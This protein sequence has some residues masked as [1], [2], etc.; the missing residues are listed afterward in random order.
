MSIGCV[1]VSTNFFN[2]K[3]MI[4]KIKIETLTTEINTLSYNDNVLDDEWLKLNE[5]IKIQ[6]FSFSKYS[7]VENYTI[8]KYDGSKVILSSDKEVEEFFNNCKFTNKELE[9]F[10][11]KKF[12]AIKYKFNIDNNKA[13]ETFQKFIDNKLKTS[14]YQINDIVS[15]KEDILY[16]MDN[17]IIPFKNDETF[18]VLN[19]DNNCLTLQNFNG[20]YFVHSDNV[21]LVKRFI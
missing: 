18:I 6:I 13:I 4:T 20:R 9:D 14:S 17:D 12:N 8:Y 3:N 19:I 15:S 10:L 11:E 5:I 2:F 7:Q 21:Y 1:K 16:D